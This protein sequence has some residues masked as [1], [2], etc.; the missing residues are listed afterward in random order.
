MLCKRLCLKVNPN[1]LHGE[2]N[3]AHK[4]IKIIPIL[5]KPYIYNGTRCSSHKGALLP[6]CHLSVSQTSHLSGE[7]PALIL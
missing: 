6:C 2:V 7:P 4:R 3:Y 1:K 5:P